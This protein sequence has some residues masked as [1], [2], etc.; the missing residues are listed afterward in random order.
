[1]TAKTLHA[2]QKAADDSFQRHHAAYRFHPRDMNEAPGSSARWLSAH[3]PQEWRDPADAPANMQPDDK[4]EHPELFLRYLQ[5]YPKPHLRNSFPPLWTA[6]SFRR[7]CPALPA[8]KITVPINVLPPCAC[9]TH[10]PSLSE[11]HCSACTAGATL[12]GFIGPKPRQ[13]RQRFV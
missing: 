11:R 5:S 13:W 7:Y 8:P 10:S 4:R 12:C 9:Q 6:I 3:R 2:R 1:M